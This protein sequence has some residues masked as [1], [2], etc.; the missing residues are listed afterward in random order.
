MKSL[1]CDCEAE[2]KKPNLRVVRCNVNDRIQWPVL[3]MALLRKE[4]LEKCFQGKLVNGRTPSENESRGPQPA[5][6][7]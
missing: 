1:D 4:C 5:K 6:G 7:G 2:K 3:E